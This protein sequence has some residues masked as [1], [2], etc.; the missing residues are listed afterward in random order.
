MNYKRLKAVVCAVVCAVLL[1]SSGTHAQQTK[2]TLYT[3]YWQAYEESKVVFV[4]QEI[5][6]VVMSS[7]LS[8]EALTG[9]LDNAAMDF[10]TFMIDA[11]SGQDLKT[12]TEKDG[13]DRDYDVEA[14]STLD[15]AIETRKEIISN[16]LATGYTVYSIHYRQNAT[17]GTTA[18]YFSPLS[19]VDCTPFTKGIIAKN[20]PKKLGR[21]TV[22]TRA[23]VG[24]ISVYIDGNYIG[25]VT[26]YLSSGDVDCYN[27]HAGFPTVELQ[28]GTHTLRAV[29]EAT[30][31][32]WTSTF[33]VNENTCYNQE[34][35]PPPPQ[36]QTYYD[37]SGY[38]DE[39]DDTL[40]DILLYGSIIGALLIL[41]LR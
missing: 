27:P 37:D 41:L 4:S 28:P 14:Y 26:V 25:A 16:A 12:L 11:L 20:A 5:C 21:V 8:D 39:E 6:K 38:Y 2:Q 9:Y 36:Q 19:S 10:D 13:F 31:T 40:L 24:N 1:L 23:N 34:L 29:V 35:S 3:Y 15:D 30:G 33:T 32:S 18:T 17:E 7:K 22:W